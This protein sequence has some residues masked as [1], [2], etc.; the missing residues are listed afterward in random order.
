MAA[1]AGGA[2]ISAVTAVDDGKIKL[3][4]IIWRVPHIQVEATRLYELNQ[5]I[6]SKQII[7]VAFSARN[8]QSTP[9]TAG[10]TDFNWRLSVSSGIEKPRW[11]I[12]GFQ[13]DKN[14]S[15]LRNPAVF[16]HV[17]L[18]NAFVKLNDQIYPQNNIPTD[19]AKN[20]YCYLYDMLFV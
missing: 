17:N 6:D 1:V 19:F 12:I 7:P 5:I 15:Q 16:D 3:S 4:K 13:T 20:K 10:L 9:I 8:T 2:G 18:S 11:I 14:T